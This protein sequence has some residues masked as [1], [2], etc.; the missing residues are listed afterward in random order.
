MIQYRRLPGD[1][2]RM[3]W[4]VRCDSTGC[5]SY[6]PFV[7]ADPEE[8]AGGASLLPG[9]WCEADIGG[10]PIIGHVCPYHMYSSTLLPPWV[11]V[12]SGDPRTVAK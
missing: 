7:M 5:D 4:R 2:H 8:L 1:V 6:S 12:P 9:G 11:D 3:L 10:A